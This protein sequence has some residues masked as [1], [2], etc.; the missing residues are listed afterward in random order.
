[1]YSRNLQ[2][3]NRSDT[4]SKADLL[5]AAVA[6]SLSLAANVQAEQGV[7][8]EA[9]LQ[10]LEQRQDASLDRDELASGEI[11]KIVNGELEMADEQLLAMSFMYVPIPL[12]VF[13]DEFTSGWIYTEG[14]A[15]DLELLEASSQVD[16]VSLQA[17]DDRKLI[18]ALAKI[19]PGDEFNFSKNEIQSLNRAA[20]VPATDLAESLEGALN[21]IIGQRYAAYRKSGLNGIEPYQRSK[22]ESV[23]AAQPLIIA[24]EKDY[25]T[26]EFFP[27]HLEF[28]LNFPNN[29]ATGIDNKFYAIEQETEGRRHFRLVHWFTTVSDDYI[30]MTQ[31]HYYS[32]HSYNVLEIIIA[33]LPYR[34]GTLV[35]MVNDTYTEQVTGLTKSIAHRIGRRM[36]AETIRETLDELRAKVTKRGG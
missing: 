13:R 7:N 36:I 4:M 21:E 3:S 28:A 24:I 33:C 9:L 20:N 14:A 19:K 30:L 35:V 15:K 16:L 23:A 8:T 18:N 2:K 17:A 1:M 11:L 5:F 26:D 12:A 27:E 31:R 10:V 22:N 6:I 25:I 29:Q 34:D 32:S